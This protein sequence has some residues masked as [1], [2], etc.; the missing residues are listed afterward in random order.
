VPP[1][2]YGQVEGE[3]SVTP[4]FECAAH[5]APKLGGEKVLADRLTGINVVNITIR[6]FTQSRLVTT[7]WK[8]VNTRTD[9]EYNIRS[10]ID[11]DEGTPRQGR[12][13]EML[14]EVGLAP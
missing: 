12:Y 13:F 2:D 11:P 8:I 9:V 4:E 5:I 6:Q 1:P 10:I 14:C 7:A 3:W